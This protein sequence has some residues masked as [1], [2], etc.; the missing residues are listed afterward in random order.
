METPPTYECFKDVMIDKFMENRYQFD[1]Y[2]ES[3]KKY[4]KCTITSRM[5]G[6][7]CKCNLEDL[8][9]KMSYVYLLTPAGISV[10]TK[11][12]IKCAAYLR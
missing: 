3:I 2:I 9:N 12:T 10:K 6:M 5:Y 1:K 4:D 7:S 11:L 8:K